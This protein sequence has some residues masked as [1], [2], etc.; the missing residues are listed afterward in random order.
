[1]Q[2]AISSVPVH[3]HA[4]SLPEISVLDFFDLTSSISNFIKN[5]KINYTCGPI[6][7]HALIELSVLAVHRV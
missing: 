1:M 7:E 3:I 5:Q 2:S 4:P 6:I